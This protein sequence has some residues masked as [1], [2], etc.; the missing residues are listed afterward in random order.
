MIFTTS[1]VALLVSSSTANGFTSGTGS[2]S[3]GSLTTKST[4]IGASYLDGL[5]M[6]G[7]MIVEIAPASSALTRQEGQFDLREPQGQHGERVVPDQHGELVK[8]HR[9]NR[10][11]VSVGRVSKATNTLNKHSTT[12]TTDC[13]AAIFSHKWNGGV[14][15]RL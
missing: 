1:A 14:V 11:E 3:D 8:R 9:L 2:P 10:Q 6:A 15:R 13:N 7:C 12:S 4:P 5:R